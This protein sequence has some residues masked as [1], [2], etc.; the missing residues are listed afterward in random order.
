ME[1]G[2]KIY[3]AVGS[4]SDRCDVDTITGERRH[5][6]FPI[7]LELGRQIGILRDVRADCIAL[8]S[9]PP[10]EVKRDEHFHAIVGGRLICKPQLLVRV[11]ISADVQG[12]SVD[13]C[14][15]GVLHIVVIVASTLAVAND[16]NL[17]RVSTGFTIQ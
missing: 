11:R 9:L 14:I 2:C 13:A 6:Y 3:I 8:T 4:C 15:L 17:M 7:N 5:K 10:V 16:A 12:E 1:I